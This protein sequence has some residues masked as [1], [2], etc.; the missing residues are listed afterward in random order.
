[1]RDFAV[2]DSTD[3][4]DCAF[5]GHSFQSSHHRSNNDPNLLFVGRSHKVVCVFNILLGRADWPQG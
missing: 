5:L 4:E 3:D 2:T 1:M